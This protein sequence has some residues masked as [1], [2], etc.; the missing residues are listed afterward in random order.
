MENDWQ[1][2]NIGK[3]VRVAM[4]MTLLAPTV[5]CILIVFTVL[6]ARKELN[7]LTQN[8]DTILESTKR[9]SVQLENQQVKLYDAI[10]NLDVFARAKALDLKEDIDLEMTKLSSAV[11]GFGDEKFKGD[12]KDIQDLMT[13]YYE[14]VQE[15][16]KRVFTTR[17]MDSVQGLL[18]DNGD[19]VDRMLDGI[20]ALLDDAP[21][22]FEQRVE[23]LGENLDQARVLSLV[24]LGF[25]VILSFSFG[26]F[27]SRKLEK[28]ILSMRD[29]ED[30]L[31]KN[32]KMDSLGQLSAGLAHEINT[33]LQYITDFS[34]FL[35]YSGEQFN[36]LRKDTRK[37]LIE[38]LGG[39]LKEQDRENILKR[40]R[41]LEEENSLEETEKMFQ[42]A[43]EQVDDGLGRITKLVRSMRDLT[44]QR[45]KTVQ[46]VPL[47][48]ILSS[49]I[50]LTTNS[51]RFS[52]TIF[53]PDLPQ[54]LLVQV[55]PAEMIQAIINIIM[56]AAE[57]LLDMQESGDMPKGPDYGKIFIKIII[58]DD[59]IDISIQDNGPGI[60]SEI[61]E[62][63]FDPFFT[64][65]EVGEGTG[66]GLSTALR[67]LRERHNGD[68]RCVSKE[69]LG[70]TF[71]VS[72]LNSEKIPNGIFI[73][74]DDSDPVVELEEALVP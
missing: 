29:L 45:G 20:E 23:E 55:C 72:I 6:N 7:S 24:S 40:L 70:S 56:N 39:D 68:I 10:E 18:D 42:N 63:I 64:T 47:E 54:N 59:R 67:I 12:F 37:L 11:M 65:K 58:K 17:S 30:S 38:A 33:P 13:P 14:G 52:A 26:F 50:A 8:F 74:G 51:V 4:I 41:A 60:P 66:Q 43:Q 31:N 35:G 53:K 32:Q 49:A 2:W 48:D 71:I 73:K 25:A 9:L 28:Q 69:G 57:A 61:R 62:K 46:K 36:Q 5:A 3:L 21:R 22:V 27:A 34:Y 15:I 1:N 16:S 19:D 44:D